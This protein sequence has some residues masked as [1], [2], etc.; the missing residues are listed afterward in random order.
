[1]SIERVYTLMILLNLM[2]APICQK[3]TKLALLL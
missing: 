3:V 2:V 1:M